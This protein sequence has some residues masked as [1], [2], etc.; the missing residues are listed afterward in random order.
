MAADQEGLESFDYNFVE[1]P[2]EE[3]ICPI[4]LLVLCDPHQTDCCGNH[5]CQR[6]IRK[7]LDTSPSMV[8]PMCRVTNLTTHLD[9]FH[10]R[11]VHALK[12]RCPQQSNGCPWVG[13]LGNVKRHLDPVSGQCSAVFPC[14]YGCGQRLLAAILPAHFAECDH[15]P[16]RCDYCLE[17]SGT[18]AEVARDHVPVCPRYPVPCPNGCSAKGIQRAS[19]RRH[20]TKCPLSVVECEYKDVGCTA[21]INKQGMASHCSKKMPQHLKMA[22][23]AYVWLSDEYHR[24]RDLLIADVESLR[25]KLAQVEAELSL[26]VPDLVSVQQ[27]VTVQDREIKDYLSQM[28]SLQAELKTAHSQLTDQAKLQQIIQKQ[29]KQLSSQQLSVQSLQD[30]LTAKD[31]ELKEYVAQIKSLQEDIKTVQRQA[32][33]HLKRNEVLQNEVLA[34]R[35]QIQSLQKINIVTSQIVQAQKSDILQLKITNDE[36]DSKLVHSAST[37][38]E[39]IESMGTLQQSLE[40]KDYLLLSMKSS[41]EG[42]MAE[43]RTLE[44]SVALREE[45]LHTLQAKY[46]INEPDCTIM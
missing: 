24:E 21:K 5:F 35:S 46:T 14:K 1:P 43:V 18:Y 12:L 2:D 7:Q 25:E 11:K 19:V 3:Y 20:L 32:Q 34:H 44:Q 9:K 17:Y 40:S 31:C 15:R 27:R 33:S 29:T 6:C 22:Y 37:I 41:L 45:Q 30:K 39:L 26:K 28:Q 36:K 4:C 38:K 42:R 23:S 13:E 10:L 16:Y 8:C